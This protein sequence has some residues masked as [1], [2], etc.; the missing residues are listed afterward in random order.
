[1]KHSENTSLFKAA[2]LR[3]LLRRRRASRQH[4][5]VSRWTCHRAVEATLRRC[6]SGAQVSDD[7]QTR[8]AGDIRLIAPVTVAPSTRVLR[9]RALTFRGHKSANASVT[10]QYLAV[11]RGLAAAA[12]NAFRDRFVIGVIRSG[13]GRREGEPGS[14]GR[15]ITAA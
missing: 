6:R 10:G 1:M 4:G 14:L 13:L 3:H 11:R 7:A 5:S 2:L 9:H 15:Y 12:D 8:S